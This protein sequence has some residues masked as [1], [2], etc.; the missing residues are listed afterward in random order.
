MK[1]L[2]LGND[3]AHL[4]NGVQEESKNVG[5]STGKRGVVSGNPKDQEKETKSEKTFPKQKNKNTPAKKAE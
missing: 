2:K 4:Y 5:D 3:Y 1:N